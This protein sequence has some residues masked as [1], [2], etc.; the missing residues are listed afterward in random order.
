[1]SHV[2]DIMRGE[3]TTAL[4]LT[5]CT[6]VRKAG[7][8]LLVDAHAALTEVKAANAAKPTARVKPRVSSARMA[9]E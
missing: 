4:G 3:L 9:A 2:L 7:R 8:D 5:G 6:D 1:M